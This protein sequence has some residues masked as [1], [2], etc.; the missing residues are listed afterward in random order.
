MEYPTCRICHQDIDPEQAEGGRGLC[1][2]CQ[3]KEEV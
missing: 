1:P 3:V 2:M